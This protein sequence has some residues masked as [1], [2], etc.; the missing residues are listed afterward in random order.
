MR[1]LFLLVPLALSGCIQQF[2]SAPVTLQTERGQVVCQ[3]Y[4]I[5]QVVYDTATA[6]PSNMTEEEADAYCVAEGNRL[7]P[8]S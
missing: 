4:G 1:V 8:A 2:E 3:L 5:N 7:L 6:W